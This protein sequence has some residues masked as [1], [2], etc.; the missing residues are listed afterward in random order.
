MIAR[1]HMALL[2]SSLLWF[3]AWAL[4]A[5]WGPNLWDGISKK[6]VAD[7]LPKMADVGIDTSTTRYLLRW[8]G[9]ALA[10]VLILFAFVL[11]M[12][13]VAIGLAYLVYVA[14][15]FLL[16]LRIAQRHRALRDQLV[17][18]SAALANATRAK[19]SLAQGLEQVS[20]ETPAPLSLELKRI[21]KDYNGGRPFADS[22]RAVQRR[23]K[24]EEF[25]VFSSAIC[26]YLEGGGNVSEALDKIASGI[27]EMQRLQRKIDA[28]TAAGR[29]MAFI[30]A[31][32]PLAFLAGLWMLDP[33]SVDVLFNTL[34][35]QLV[36]L[37]VGVLV[38]FAALWCR[39][40]LR[41][42]A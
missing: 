9:F 10:G 40:I 27:R 24:L 22:F 32:F 21:V 18:A 35:G 2:L 30:L 23:L 41:I 34:M 37:F 12:T 28:D 20:E 11:R 42:D 4:A 7:L 33:T 25:T 26:V 13:P 5:W 36:L 3:A 16:D 31:A 19:L 39:N 1:R 38:Y 29:K 14:P 8:W 17:R 6:H 15:R